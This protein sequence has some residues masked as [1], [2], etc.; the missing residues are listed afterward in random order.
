MMTARIHERGKK[1]GK[2]LTTYKKPSNEDLRDAKL[3][4]D[5]AN[6][7]K[8]LQS[9]SILRRVVL[10]LKSCTR[11]VVSVAFALLGLG[12]LLLS[13]AVV[14]VSSALGLQKPLDN[15]CEWQVIT[16]AECRWCDLKFADP[17]TKHQH[18]SLC[19]N[20][21]VSEDIATRKLFDAVVARGNAARSTLPARLLP[22]RLSRLTGLTRIDVFDGQDTLEDVGESGSEGHTGILSDLIFLMDVQKFRL[23]NLLTKCLPRPHLK[24]GRSRIQWQCSCGYRSFDDFLELRQ[25]AINDMEAFMRQKALSER[26]I[27]STSSVFSMLAHLSIQLVY[28]KDHTAKSG[29]LPSNSNS[30][31]RRSTSGTTTTSSS[32]LLHVL[33]S[34]PFYSRGYKLCQPQ[35]R[36][37]RTD[38]DFFT[39]LQTSYRASR[40]SLKRSLSLQTISAIKFIR[41][42][43]YRSSLVDIRKVDDL[44]PPANTDYSYEPK[45]PNLVPPIGENHMMHLLAHPSHADQFDAVL[46]KRIPK[47]NGLLFAD[48][49]KGTVQ[50]WGIHFIEGWHYGLLWFVFL[51]VFALGSL[52]F[53]ICWIVLEHDV[54]GAS[55][56]A[57]YFLTLISAIGGSLQAAIETELI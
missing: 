52:I 36:S 27:P 9:A 35:V 24:P 41:F 46:L 11:Y 56:V 6:T 22:R 32:N 47:K 26:T 25:G 7:Q 34:F 17:R 23:V 28:G 18:E 8:P 42:E 33:L 30:L 3:A 5:V 57:A 50:G 48:P 12:C 20:N 49:V 44:P 14:A 10:C 15:E 55:A 19:H 31:S 51:L 37:V 53:L 21:E 16:A 1:L 39:L 29:E 40:S 4:Q 2:P 45:P 13:I 54:Q 38:R 43:M